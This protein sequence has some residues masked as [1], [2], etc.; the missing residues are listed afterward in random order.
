MVNDLKLRPSQEEALEFVKSNRKA[1]AL[2]LSTAFGKTFLSEAVARSCG[3]TAIITYANAL[4]R[5]HLQLFPKNNLMIGMS[6]YRH[7]KD[8]ELAVAR[9]NNETTL[10]NAAS[11]VKYMSRPDSVPFDTVIIDEADSCLGLFALQSGTSI[12]IEVENPSL[13]HVLEALGKAGRVEHKVLHD[14]LVA[15]QH[16]YYWRVEEKKIKGAESRVCTIRSVIP[17]LRTLHLPDHT[18]LMSGTLFDSHIKEYFRDGEVAKYEA[19][20]PIPVERRPID[21]FTTDLPYEPTIENMLE[22]YALVEK[23]YTERPAIF[24]VT[25][26]D[27]QALKEHLLAKSYAHKDEKV[28]VLYNLAKGDLALAPGATIGL[29]LANDRARLNVILRGA[30]PNLGDEY[31]RKRAAMDGGERWYTD[32]VLRQTVQACGRVCRTPEDYGRTVITDPRIIMALGCNRE[33]LPKYFVE[34]VTA[35]NLIK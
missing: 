3:R 7:S 4:V 25:Y 9:S 26:S 22:F 11:F 27:V 14:R 5:Q 28:S 35:W 21:F 19:P 16:K 33:V 18:V 12:P 1:T 17:N 31:V 32:E 6:N 2:C 29:D 20:S 15:N 10:F 30:F 13:E 34:A 23:A 8:Y 24:H